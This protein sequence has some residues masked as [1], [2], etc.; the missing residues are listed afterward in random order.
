MMK[1]TDSLQTRIL[2]KVD[3]QILHAHWWQLS[4]ILDVHTLLH[5]GQKYGLRMIG[6]LLTSQ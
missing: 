5:F 2:G 4:L 3:S 1:M 6:M